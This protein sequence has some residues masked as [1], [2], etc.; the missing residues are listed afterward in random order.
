MADPEVDHGLAY[1]ALGEIDI[2]RS[3]FYKPDWESV[4][5]YVNHIL[6]YLVGMIDLQKPKT[7]WLIIGHPSPPPPPT[8]SPSTKVFGAIFLV[9]HH[10]EILGTCVFVGCSVDRKDPKDLQ[11][12]ITQGD[13]EVLPEYSGSRSQKPNMHARDLEVIKADSTEALK[14]DMHVREED[15]VTRGCNDGEGEGGREREEGA[16]SGVLETEG[17]AVECVADETASIVSELEDAFVIRW[18]FDGEDDGIV[19]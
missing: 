7:H 19:F 18:G 12:K 6:Y 4:E 11:T 8:T 3:P 16:V 9:R 1:N 10:K 5:D 2:L 14:P 17:D 13:V 15:P